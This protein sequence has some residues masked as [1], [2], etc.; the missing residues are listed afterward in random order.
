MEDMTCNGLTFMD[1]CP[2]IH[3]WSWNRLAG[4]SQQLALVFFSIPVGLFCL[5][6]SLLCLDIVRAVQIPG[7]TPR[8]NV[9]T[10][11]DSIEQRPGVPRLLTIEEVL[12]SEML[13]QF[14]WERTHP[15][16]EAAEHDVPTS[17]S[18]YVSGGRG[19]LTKI[20]QIGPK[21]PNMFHYLWT[22]PANSD[23]WETGP[24]WERWFRV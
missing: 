18:Y 19:S 13:G 5:R 14:H 23:R 4:P 9:S 22:L 20:A 8:Q 1:E 11:L 10:P 16:H 3:V 12:G 2:F 6:P 15:V 21:H 24:N 17:M 7:S